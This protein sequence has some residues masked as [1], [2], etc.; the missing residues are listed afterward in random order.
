MVMRRGDNEFKDKISKKNKELSEYLD[1][2]RVN[3]MISNACVIMATFMSAC[4]FSE[5]FLDSLNS[6]PVHSCSKD[7]G[8][9][10]GTY[11]NVG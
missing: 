8:H 7:A 3:K 5:P 1:E 4:G 10:V 11:S 6:E 2:I 9:N